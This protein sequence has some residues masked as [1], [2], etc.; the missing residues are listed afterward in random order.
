[1]AP[2]DP[3]TTCFHV[4]AAYLGEGSLLLLLSHRLFGTPGKHRQ[5]ERIT[6]ARVTMMGWCSALLLQKHHPYRHTDTYSALFPRFLSFCDVGTRFTLQ[7]QNE[8]SYKDFV[9]PSG[10]ERGRRKRDRGFQGNL[11]VVIQILYKEPMLPLLSENGGALM[12]LCE[13]KA[14]QQAV[15]TTWI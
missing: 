13:S 12:C 14:S 8:Q 1:M 2:E 9:F 4:S 11:I 10:R 7:Q 6:D 5:G 3:D 15:V